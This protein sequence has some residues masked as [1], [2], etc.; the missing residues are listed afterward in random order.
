MPAQVKE[1]TDQ[2]TGLKKYIWRT[3]I[4]AHKPYWKEWFENLTPIF[5]G[6]KVKRSLLL[7]KDSLDKAL[8]EGFETNKF[9]SK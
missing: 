9:Y 3:E 7:S 1:V 5:L 6:L 8:L 2:A 4:L